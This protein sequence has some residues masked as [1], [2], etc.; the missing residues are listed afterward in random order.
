MNRYVTANTTSHCADTSF[1]AEYK[2]F[3]VCSSP[4]ALLAE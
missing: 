4:L 1:V 2:A 3:L